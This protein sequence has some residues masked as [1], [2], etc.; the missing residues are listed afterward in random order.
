MFFVKPVIYFARFVTK[1][2]GLV[3]ALLLSLLTAST[4]FVFG[5]QATSAGEP[6][7]S[8]RTDEKRND[9]RIGAG[10]VLL[11]EVAGEPDLRRKVK[12]MEQGTIRLP[13]IDH[14]IK[15]SG[16]TEREMTELLRQEFIV[17]LKEPQ[18]TLYIDEYHARMASIAGAVNQSKQVALTREIRLYDLI[19]MAGGLT[20]KAGNIVQLIHT[21]PEDSL[22]IIDI[23]ELVRRPELNRVIRDGDFVNVP[24]A[25][26]IY[27]TGNVNKPGSFPIKDSI[28]LSQAIAM[29]GGVAADSRKKEIRLVRANDAS[30]TAATEQIVNLLEIEKDPGKDIILKPYDVVMVPESTRTK[31]TKTLIQAFAGGLASALG[32]GIL[33]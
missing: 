12:V 6:T 32:W 24:E 8:N 21:R 25:G 17:I 31:Q 20:D 15:V 3:V 29:A 22:D 18:V 23:R 9:Y 14:D 19:S 27:V 7:S 13:Y 30:Q 10:D 16:L 33:R 4:T 5:Q 11:I 26:I 1:D 2:T 28:K